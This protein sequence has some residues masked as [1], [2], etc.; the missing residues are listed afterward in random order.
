M[1]DDVDGNL[2]SDEEIN[3]EIR[4]IALGRMQL[5]QEPPSRLKHFDPDDSYFSE[6]DSEEDAKKKKDK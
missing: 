4:S 6:V 1:L 3:E 2:T 5:S